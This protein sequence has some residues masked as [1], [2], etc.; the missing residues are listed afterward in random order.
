MAAMPFSK[1]TKGFSD[2]R[3]ALI[4]KKQQILLMEYDLV[5]QL[6][7]DQDLTSEEEAKIIKVR[8]AA[9]SEVESQSYS[10]IQTLERYVRALGGEL[11]ILAKFPDREVTLNQFT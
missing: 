9:F 10:M 8:E 5:A 2:K 3:K 11:E 6:R 1:L 4:D 7:E